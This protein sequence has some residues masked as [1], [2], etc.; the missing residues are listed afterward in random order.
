MKKT[1]HTIDTIRRVVGPVIL[2]EN[3]MNTLM[4]KMVKTEGYR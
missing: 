2:V 1:G 3:V 4:C